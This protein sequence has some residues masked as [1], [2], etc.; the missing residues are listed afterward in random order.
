[1]GNPIGLIAAVLVLSLF[2]GVPSTNQFQNWGWRIPFLLSS[3]LVVLGVVVRGRIRETPEFERV[4]R[5]AR[6]GGPTPWS[7]QMC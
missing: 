7:L 2:N 4:R 1:M 6:R 3:A 5:S